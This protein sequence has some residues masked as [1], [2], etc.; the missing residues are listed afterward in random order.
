VL[1][2]Y[3]F[4]VGDT[5]LEQVRQE[6]DSWRVERAA[7][8]MMLRHHAGLILDAA[9]D[10]PVELV[11]GPTLAALYPPGLRP[12]GDIDLLVAP[13][14][15]PQLNEILPELGFVRLMESRPDLL[16]DAWVHRDNSVL[17]VEVHTNLVHL[18]RMRA[19][20]SMTYG[21]LADNFHRPGA[22][23]AVAVVHSGMHYFALLRHVV[24]ICQAARGVVTSEEE[25]LFE[26]LA[27]RSGTRMVAVIGLTL[28]G[29][30]LGER[31]CLDIAQ[32]LGSMGDYRFA[33]TLIE[34][35]VLT[36]PFDG[37][38]IYNG[39]RRVIFR[40]LLRKGALVAGGSGAA[41]V[42]KTSSAP[43]VSPRTI[44]SFWRR[45]SSGT[46]VLAFTCSQ[47]RPVMLRH[48]IMQMQRQ[49]Y[50]V[51]HVIYVNSAEEQTGSHTS[52]NYG[53]LLEDVCRNTGGRTRIAY[54]PS[55]TYHQ[56]HCKA[57]GLAQIDDYDLFLKVDDDDIYLKDYVVGVVRDFEQ[58]LWDY[59]GGSSQGHLN[60]YRWKPDVILTGLGL[61]EGEAK[62]GIPEVMPP[63]LAFSRR[64]IRELL[65]IKDDGN[66][67]DIQWRHHLA[68]VPGILMTTRDERNFIYHIHRGNASTRS[69]HKA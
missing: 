42:R 2:H 55:G 58:Y 59:S 50:P 56:N 4:P 66:F 46:R 47:H 24:D 40:E 8:S 21:D 62:M 48:C 22:L 63:T 14:A 38:I 11:K 31:R 34:G 60:G 68:Q 51:D 65:A 7:L 29:R 44:G 15:L 10:L 64:A 36:A 23:L 13:A 27:E 9:S 49:S 32:A 69:W 25:S 39:W 45:R 35:A 30:L 26:L 67:E 6:A 18:S 61:G 1:R 20:F 3:P 12:F 19:A 5:T 43:L 57:I 17:M 37:R 52:L 16:E 28:A 41:S 54:G 53:P 33:R